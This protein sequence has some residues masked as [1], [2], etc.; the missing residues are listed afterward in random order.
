MYTPRNQRPRCSDRL[1]LRRVSLALAL[2]LATL[3]SLA[4]YQVP[5]AHAQ[6][7]ASSDPIIHWDQSMIYAGQNNGNPEGPVGE[8]AVV[9]GQNFPA[10]TALI[11][12]VVAGDTNSDPTLC[13]APGTGGAVKVG[14]IT[15]DQSGSF[16][17]SFAWP[18]GVGGSG[19]TRANSVCTYTSSTPATLVSSKDDGPFTVLTDNKPTFS[20][21]TTSVA[22]GTNVTVSGQ[23]WVPPQPIN[24]TIASC[25]DCDPGAGAII[26][27]GTTSSAGLTTGTFSVKI[28]IPANMPPNNYVVNVSTQNGPLDA[29]HIDGL[30]VKQLTVTAAA[31]PTPTAEPS[32]SVTADASPTA[33]ATTTTTTP[34]TNSSDSNGGGSPVIVILIVLIVLLL[35]IGGAIFFILAR[36]KQ[37]PTGGGMPG[38]PPGPFGTNQAGAF[39]QQR[40]PVTPFPQSSPMNTPA[41]FNQLPGQGGFNQQ[42]SWQGQPQSSNAGFN[43]FQ[44]NQAWPGNQSGLP[45]N[46][47]QGNPQSSNAGFNGFQ[48]N[49]PFQ[50]QPGNMMPGQ[51]MPAQQ[52]AMNRQCMR[53][54]SPLPPNSPMCSVCGTYNPTSNPNDPTVAY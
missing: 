34:A 38:T 18:A 29:Y 8:T 26:A 25:A 20:L 45:Q 32:P 49:Q 17:T 4:V 39:N 22:A 2:A 19:H 43:G 52:A 33:A 46:S 5:L 30:G 24:I 15:S 14:S 21:S 7:T 37:P 54:G 51:G 53:C 6:S 48:Q 12:V 13:K 42:G 28:S 10:S 23:N 36:R 35:G 1:S 47:W 11:L 44:Q 27:G 3:L 9:H 31:T 40:T 41:G 16:T 50:S